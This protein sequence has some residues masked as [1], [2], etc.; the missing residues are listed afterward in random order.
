MF[1]GTPLWLSLAGRLH[2]LHGVRGGA[3]PGDARQDGAQAALVLQAVR[4]GRQRLHWPARAAQHHQ[5]DDDA[6]CWTSRRVML[7][8]WFI[9][10][11]DW[12]SVIRQSRGQRP[13]CNCNV[14]YY[15]Y[16]LQAIRA[17]NGTDSQDTTAEDFTN[18]VFDRIDING[19]GKWRFR[20]EESV[21]GGRTAF[22]DVSSAP[23]AASSPGTQQ[24]Q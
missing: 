15:Y 18:R 10:I 13:V 1:W 14:H 20:E 7:T 11:R 6:C 9:V 23:S 2:R 22:L 19:D 16:F 24:P 5:G 17:I 3:Q 21:V 12:A 4:R 8:D